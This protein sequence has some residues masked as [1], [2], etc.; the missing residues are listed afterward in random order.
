[1]KPPSGLRGSALVAASLLTLLLPTAAP[2][3]PPARVPVAAARALPQRLGPPGPP[4]GVLRQTGCTIT[5]TTA[6]CDLWAKTGQLV[7]PGAA[8]PAP[9]WG[10][11]STAD[12]PVGTP[13]PVLVVDQDDTVTVTVHNGL[14]T[15]LA[16]AVPTMTGLVPDTSGAA[17][18]GT[19]TYTFKAGRPGTY[20]YEAGHT[21]NGARQAMMGL[22]GALVVRAPASG[23]KPSVYGDAGSTYDD[24]AVLVLSELDPAFNAATDPLKTD[25]RSYRPKYRLIN[26][27]AFPETDPVAT[28]VG[29]KVLLRYVNAGVLAH[30]MTVLGVDQSVVGQDSRPT[31]YPE[32]AV[33][34][35][36]PPGQSID[37]ISALPAG[38][39]GRRFL[40]F[41]SGSLLNNTGQRVGAA[42]AGVS[43]QQAFGGMMTY[44]DTNPQPVSGDHIGPTAG[45]TSAAPSPASVTTPVTV[46]ADFSD[47]AT[48]NSPIDRAEVVVDD[49]SVAEGTGI[50]FTTGIF[51]APSV[52][53]ATATLGTADLTKLS[54]GRH[55]LWVRA[56]DTAG[57]WGAVDSVTI[58][59]SVTGASTTGLTVTPNPVGGIVDLAIN[60]TGDDS[61]LGGTVA[62]AEYFVDAA[63]VNGTGTALSLNAPGTAI[64]AETGVVPAT[65]V[66]ALAE[67]RHT[68]LVHTLDS[69]GLW[70]PP[71]TVD[72]IVDRTG[73]TL[74]SGAVLPATTNG[75]NGSPSDPTDL[76]VNAAFTDTVAGG[77]H[78]G[79]VAA[80]GFID[81]AGADGSG[82]AFLALDGSYGQQTE[83]TYALVPLSELT[84]LADG[85]HQMLVHSRDTAGNWGPLTGVTFTVDRKGPVVTAT[86]IVAAGVVTLRA[87]VTDA[88][89][90]IAAAEFFE[91][92]D[93]G[94]GFA[95]PMTAGTPAGTFTATIP[96]L[97]NGAHTFSVR[98]QDSA[99]NWGAAATVTVTVTGSTLIF[100]NNFDAGAGAWSQRVGTVR[101]APAAAF[102]N[103]PALTVTGRAASYVVDNTP[104]NEATLH[105]QFGFAAGTYNTNGAIVDIFQGR[106]A[107]GTAVVNVQYRRTAANGSQLRTGLLN[108]AGAWVYSA[109]AA[110]PTTA[111]TVA[112]DWKSATAGSAGLMINGTA[113]G[114]ANGNTSNRKIESAALG[115][116]V[117]TGATTGG[118]AIDNYTSTR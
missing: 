108:S 111:S 77:V 4:A 38:Q 40:V 44:L 56:H 110:V 11:A 76:R 79:I 20:L 82:F 25:L 74:L 46:T 10:F 99:G 34:L 36:L 81:T 32:G 88:L 6:A 47:V 103:S 78:E 68:I 61:A 31:S 26:G 17:P 54:Q 39:D 109:W 83:N 52:T 57:N 101:V 113:S 65:V 98:A 3:Q 86:A 107:A 58:N 49:L 63:G 62:G 29:R 87:S 93:P 1:M 95:R 66:G 43:P 69:L 22:T 19:K 42:Q 21:A 80:E 33:T 48:G 105:V 72:V 5:G 114:T 15:A 9:I 27:K 90:G 91:G 104:A 116:I 70:G 53:A 18:G 84:R 2:A 67:G 30:P 89:S 51:G 92:A 35:P 64:S 28:D 16:L 24:E 115:V 37:A 97:A 102:G 94:V 7:L 73:P 59:L 14:G 100:A 117:S 13:G 8:A 106:N 85:A 118:G 60:A 50:A 23:G 71:A 41:E 12:A 45:K 75:L 112:V 55:T 96:G